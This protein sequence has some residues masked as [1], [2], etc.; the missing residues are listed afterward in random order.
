[1]EKIITYILI[2]IKK[3]SVFFSAQE[4]N[5]TRTSTKKHQT[6]GQKRNFPININNQKSK[7]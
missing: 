5:K 3:Y 2:I 1:M 4:N 7:I 6:Q